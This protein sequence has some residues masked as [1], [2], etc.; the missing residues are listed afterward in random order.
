MTD[1]KTA[2]EFQ[3][4]LVREIARI[5]PWGI[6]VLFLLWM[7]QVIVVKPLVE[8][9]GDAAVRSVRSAILENPRVIVAVKQNVK[10][11]MEFATATA[12][13]T[14]KSELNN[15]KFMR[16]VKDNVKKGIDYAA[17][18]MPPVRLAISPASSK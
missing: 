10:E 7:G 12:V 9:L 2:S 4:T 15:R 16:R 3:E 11:A 6:L 14:V 8:A 5:I 1:Q 13:R 17:E 18:R